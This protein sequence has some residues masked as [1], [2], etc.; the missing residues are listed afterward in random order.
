MKY[1]NAKKYW[2]MLKEVSH[3]SYP[4]N[5]TAD[6][7]SKYFKAINNPDDPFYQAD[8]DII[9]FNDRFMRQEL[10]VMF[11]EL[12]TPMNFDEILKAIKQLRSGASGGSDLIINEIFKNG[13]DYLAPYLCKLFDTCFTTGYFPA[14]WTDGIIVPIHKGGNTGDL[15]NYRG[16]TLLSAFG[17]LFTRVL[18]NRLTTWAETYNVYI[19][20]QA[21]FRSGMGTVDNIFILNSLISHC[22]S[23]NERLFCAFV[24]FKKAFD[25]VVRDILWYKLIKYGVRG[26]MLKVIRSMYQT[27]KSKVKVMNELSES[28]IC[29]LGVR[30]GE[31]LS[32]F[33]FSMFLNDLEETLLIKGVECIDIGTLNLCVLLYA[34]DLILF[35]RS[36][37]GLQRSLDI[38]SEYCAKWKLIVNTQKTKIMIFRKAGRLPEHLHFYYNDSE[39][40]IVNT[41]KYL[42]VV[43][44]SG[45]AFQEQDKAASGQALKALF[46]LNKYL[47][48]FTDISPRHQ[49]DLFDKMISPIL[50]Y[51]SEVF[52][53]SKGSQIERVHLSFCK[54]VLGVKLSTQNNFVYGETGRLP[55]KILW[56]SNMIRYWLKLCLSPEIKYIK[57]VYNFLKEQA[58]RR[59]NIKNWV[60]NVKDLLSRL[61]F[62]DVWLNQGVANSKI[63]MSILKQR[64][65]DNY[66]Q[67]WTEQ[68]QASSRALFYREIALFE[69]SPYLDIVTVTKFRKS[70]T[71]LRLSSHRLQIET[72]R[73]N[74]PLSIPINERK[75]KFCNTLEDEYHFVIECPV[76]LDLRKQYIKSYYWTRPNFAKF[77]ELIN[78][79][80]TT[81]VRKLATFVFKAFEK[82]DQILKYF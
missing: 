28:F 36:A 23:N 11:E 77:K 3:V 59:P 47:Y 57:I 24:D 54:R 61:G 32:P 38:L 40:E 1:T 12:E 75:C 63:F 35:A 69:Y 67:T 79:N 56:Q 80:N 73:W 64:I 60:S 39:I 7:F 51:S 20:A 42:G 15:G 4:K 22:L 8:E 6:M 13:V 62:Y 18:N 70:F 41:F 72:G 21:G 10:D 2:S 76:Y 53:F 58:D 30:Q 9:Y 66:F 49:F 26:K 71:R 50:N 45:G 5:I 52:G 46:Q 65:K 34:D 17:K 74:K 19:E 81:M 78:S 82:R 25:F 31:C 16:I 27:V 68:L 43:F 44:S 29:D 14:A 55:L 33:L 37:E 48:K